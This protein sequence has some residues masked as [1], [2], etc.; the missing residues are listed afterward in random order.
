MKQL[1]DRGHHLN[2]KGCLHRNEDVGSTTLLLG[3]YAESW[4]N[5]I[6][7]SPQGD[8]PK[9]PSNREPQSEKVG[10]FAVLATDRAV[11]RIW[12]AEL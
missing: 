11:D 10:I 12:S 2:D 5:L 6:A 3:E 7:S 9:D 8:Y 1:G 4:G